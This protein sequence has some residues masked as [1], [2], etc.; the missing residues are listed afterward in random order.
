MSLF[1]AIQAAQA[2]N[3]AAA[4]TAAPTLS[5]TVVDGERQVV[6]SA[7]LKSRP[8]APEDLVGHTVEEVVG[9]L[10]IAAGQ[11]S[12][13]TA[14]LYFEDGTTETVGSDYVFGEDPQYSRVEINPANTGTLG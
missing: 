4:P 2:L 11:A 7:S 9:M 10:G 5:L 3:N 13:G 1:S 8:F 6:V 14:V 12:I